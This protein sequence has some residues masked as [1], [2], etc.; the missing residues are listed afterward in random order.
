MSHMDHQEDVQEQAEKAG[1]SAIEHEQAGSKLASAAWGD[2]M[3]KGAGSVSDFQDGPNRNYRELNRDLKLKLDINEDGKADIAV[4]SKEG[5]ELL[6]KLGLMQA[7]SSLGRGSEFHIPRHRSGKDRSEMKIG[8]SRD[9][10]FS[11]GLDGDV[12][13]GESGKDDSPAQSKVRPG[14]ERTPIDSW[15]SSDSR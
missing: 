14:I 11:K 5:A 15:K 13:S 4:L 8:L 12:S 6:P 10:I 1:A 9:P 3:Q 7:G 2:Q